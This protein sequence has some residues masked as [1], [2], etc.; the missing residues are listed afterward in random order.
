MTAPDPWQEMRD[1]CIAQQQALKEPMIAAAMRGSVNDPDYRTLLG[2][3]QAF[4][5]M[6]SYIHGARGVK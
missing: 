4:A 5:R 3:S 6:R 2:Q 1:W